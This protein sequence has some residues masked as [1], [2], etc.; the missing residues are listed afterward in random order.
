MAKEKITN[1][2][3]ASREMLETSDQELR[4][5]NAAGEQPEK[6]SLSDELQTQEEVQGKTVAERYASIVLKDEQEK[7]SNR[8]KARI[9]LFVPAAI[10]EELDRMVD[11]KEIKNISHFIN[12][13]I[14]DYLRC[15]DQALNEE[16]GN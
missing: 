11:H 15:R 13:L 2:F 12:Y 5:R 3:K 16:Q 8:E 10:K 1:R 6:G 14:V 7:H 4:M 9:N